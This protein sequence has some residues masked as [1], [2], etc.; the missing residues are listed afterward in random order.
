VI[1]R[2][3]NTRDLLG[4]GSLHCPAHQRMV[5]YIVDNYVII[6]F[7]WRKQES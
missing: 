4:G 6:I 7:L 3:A 1:A 5:L 2:G